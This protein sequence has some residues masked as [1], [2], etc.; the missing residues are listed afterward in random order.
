MAEQVNGSLPDWVSR[1]N[2]IAA[3]PLWPAWDALLHYG[4][5]LASLPG[6][7]TVTGSVEPRLL[8]GPLIVVAN[9]IGDYDAIVLAPS[10]YKVG[11]RPRFMATRGL[12][13]AKG[14]GT[15]LERAGFIRVDRG[16]GDARHALTV[17]DAVLGN[18]GHIVVYPEGRIGLDRDLWPERGRSGVARMALLSR[19]PVIPVTSWGAH[20]V[21]CY[22]D[23]ARKVVSFARSI[24][25]QPSMQV[26]VGPPVPLDDLN[27][28][29]MGDTNRA[30]VR[31]IAAITMQ[32]QELRRAE[33][34]APRYLDPTR[35]CPDESTA[36]FPGGE[37]PA[38]LRAVIGAA[39]DTP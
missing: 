28:N 22:A 10:L 35:P 23:D 6:R 39:R 16:S 1:Q 31:I 34:G 19:V 20:E 3:Q 38:E 12:M 36:A 29:R 13:T 14:L 18:N 25:R 5:P 33:P 26:Q 30:R 11:I 37:V 32:L 4:A 21:L 9:H 27:A 7:V 8:A 15:L 17:T 24:W 2:K